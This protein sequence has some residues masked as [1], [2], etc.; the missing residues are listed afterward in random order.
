MMKQ[1]KAVQQKGSALLFSFILLIALTFIAIASVN[2]GIME[3]KMATNIEEQMNAFQMANAAI[4]FVLSDTDT[5]LPKASGGTVTVTIIDCADGNPCVTDPA[6]LVLPTVPF[7]TATGEST[8]T[9]IVYT[10]CGPAPRGT[11]S[12]LIAFSSYAY[13]ISTD[14]NKTANGRGRSSQRQ[15]Y[16]EL[17]PKCA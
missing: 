10:A 14:V 4:D 17:G 3:V 13:R 7:T 2:T 6:G 15:G 11:G 1:L 12:S 5:N 9:D 16:L 8:T